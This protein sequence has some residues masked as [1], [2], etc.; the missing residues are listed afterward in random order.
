METAIFIAALLILCLG[1]PQLRY[2]LPAD[3]SHMSHDRTMMING[4]FMVLIILKHLCE[5]TG[6]IPQWPDTVFRAI[7]VDPLDQFVV[8]TFFFFSGYGI[9]SSIER[10]GKAYL[11]ELLSRRFTRLYFNY[12]VALL[13]MAAINSTFRY[14]PVMALRY[15]WTN[16]TSPEGCWFIFNTLVLYL[17]TWV[18]FKLFT[19]ARPWRAICLISVLTLA[20]CLALI[21][22]RPE[23]ELTTELCFP[24]GAAYCLLS[25]RIDA[26]LRRIPALPLGAAAIAVAVCVQGYIIKAT[27][28]PPIADTLY[29][30]AD[31]LRIAGKQVLAILFSLGV[32][33]LF[34]AFSWKKV[35]RPLTWLGGT[36]VFS[37]YVFQFVPIRL[38]QYW[39]FHHFSQPLY[40][41]AAFLGII[42]MAWAGHAILSRLDARIWKS[43]PR[44]SMGETLSDKMAGDT[45]PSAGPCPSRRA[46]EPCNSQRN[47]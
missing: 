15:F 43:R 2:A 9:M 32:A 36:V 41:L 16:V 47:P 21:P 35:P 8:S 14:S 5:H 31:C 28:H 34:A 3:G 20:C 7:A 42:F 13:I 44:P 19:P 11:R 18:S 10:K 26:A 30:C 46:C 4:L 29:P 37:A 33:W 17:F 25:R 23:Y 39:G 40:V 22:I 27:W 45:H 12:A 38:L 1:R 6:Y 24:A